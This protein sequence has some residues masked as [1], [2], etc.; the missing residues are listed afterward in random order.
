MKILILSY[1]ISPFRGSEY[2]VGWNYVINMSRFHHLTV[3]YGA[4]GNHMGEVDELE[5]YID[6]N[7][8]E[9]VKFIPI[10]PDK[11]T[12]IFNS[13]NK[14]GK[15]VYT[16]YLAYKRWH[17]LVFEKA[18]GI[19][20]NEEFDLVHFLNPIGY[21]EPGYLWKLNLPYVWGPIGGA[22]DIPLK[23]YKALNFNGK[24][25]FTMRAIGNFFQFRYNTRLKKAL[26]STDLL[27][28]STTENQELFKEYYLTNSYYTPEN[29]L[30]NSPATIN[31]DK[32]A[33]K[34]I[35]LVWIGSIDDRKALI[36]MLKALEKIR[37]ND[38]ELHILG[39]GYLKNKL[40]KYAHKANLNNIIWHGNISRENVF[41]ILREAHINITTSLLEGNPTVI[42]E[43]MSFNIPTITLDLSGMRDTVCNDC[44]IKIR[45]DSYNQ[46]IKDL[47]IAIDDLCFDT[48]K[49]KRLSVGVNICAQKF[50][51][52][53][54]IAFFNKIYDEA[55][56]N[57]NVRN[58]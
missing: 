27:L 15:F 9:N 2:S 1:Q 46:V 33:N 7:P 21:R 10:I 35:K 4:S 24:V 48:D 23:L 29:G 31:L 5:N 40:M 56:K 37:F 42:W 53:K 36:I 8:V 6:H 16:F 17:K 3:L 12:E 45:I 44:G 51:W 13:L 22:Q 25:K 19:I 50:T 52:N 58:K 54:R 34:T 47:A 49:L 28:T 26:A 18:K 14:K 57:F 39:D 55:V 43:A 32:F 38:Y 30:L 20:S 11:K 41:N